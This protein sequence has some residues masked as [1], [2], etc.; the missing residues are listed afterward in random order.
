MNEVKDY[1]ESNPEQRVAVILTTDGCGNCTKLID[2][3]D[4]KLVE[5]YTDIEF[6][7]FEYQLDQNIV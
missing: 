1:I 4:T 3:V 2:Y 6:V 5:K 7:I